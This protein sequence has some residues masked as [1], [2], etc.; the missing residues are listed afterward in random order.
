[1]IE[2]FVLPFGVNVFV[3][4]GWDGPQ[5]YVFKST[6]RGLFVTRDANM[7]RQPAAVNV[8]AR[9]YERNQQYLGDCGMVSFRMVECFEA[10]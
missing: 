10:S 6:F 7:D 9:Y 2:S 1:M 8:T 5:T 4:I 3:H